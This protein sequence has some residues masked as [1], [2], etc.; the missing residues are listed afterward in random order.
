MTAY[1][2]NIFS[3]MVAFWWGK[4]EIINQ[5]STFLVN[6]LCQI[7]KYYLVELN[8][9]W[10]TQCQSV[11]KITSNVNVFLRILLFWALVI[12]LSMQRP[13]V[14]LLSLQ[15]FLS[16]FKG[17]FNLTLSI[18]R[19]LERHFSSQYFSVLALSFVAP[20]WC[21]KRSPSKLAYKLSLIS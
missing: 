18:F 9:I 17:T 2:H 21:T 19:F 11:S 7:K 6:L 12:L 3:I 13:F 5:I 16:N 1:F 20:W 8:M 4:W 10:I 15:C 14:I